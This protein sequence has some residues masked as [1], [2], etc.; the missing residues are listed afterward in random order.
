AMLQ[1]DKSFASFDSSTLVGVEFRDATTSSTSYSGLTAP[2]DIANPIYSG[3]P[4]ELVAYQS[5]T[6][7]YQTQSLFLQQNLSFNDRFIAT[8]GIR[9]DWL[10]LKSSDSLSGS[11]ESDDF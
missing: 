7:D 8:A 9:H 6:T 4:G 11:S 2:I 5:T 10:D 1:Y 3:G